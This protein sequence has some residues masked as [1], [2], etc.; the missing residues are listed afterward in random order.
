MFEIVKKRP[1]TE[2]VFMMELFAPH[3]AKKRKAGQFII[4]RV[5]E[6]GERIPLTIADADP[7]AGTIRIYFQVV[8][9]TTYKLSRLEVGQ[10][11]ADVV[12]PLGRPT[13]IENFGRVVCVGGGVGVAPLY[14]ITKAMKEAGNHTI[15]II[16]A[17]TKALLILE[18]EM[19]AICDELLISTD[20]GSY[21]HKGFVTDL[22]RQ[23]LERP[24]K[25]NQV[26]AIGPPIMMK[27]VCKLTKEF[28]V[29]TIVSLN[30]IMVD[31]TGMCGACRVEV[32]G[33]TKFCCVDGPEFD[34]HAV[35]WELFMQRLTAYREQEQLSYKLIREKTGGK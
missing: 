10:R 11:L 33:E 29:P 3:I 14:P 15:G 12:G 34:G 23:V 16:G 35:N 24:E 9:T 19:R 1:I 17:R 31:G 4:I 28:N 26:V 21:G 22:L 30:P 2:E 6:V 18:D 25:V 20:D 5:D 27:F 8:G 13:H 7:E 32:G